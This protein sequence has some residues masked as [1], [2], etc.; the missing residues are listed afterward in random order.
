MT[1]LAVAQPDTP[2]ELVR[3]DEENVDEREERRPRQHGSPL[4]SSGFVV[5]VIDDRAQRAEGL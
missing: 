3:G 5:I 4:P 2:S 1:R